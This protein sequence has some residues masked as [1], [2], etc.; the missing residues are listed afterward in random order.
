MLRSFSVLFVFLALITPALA[1]SLSTPPIAPHLEPSSVLQNNR[2]ALQQSIRATAFR[3]SAELT[4]CKI[5][6]VGKAC[7]NT[8]ISRK[9][10]QTVELGTP[11][12]GR[13]R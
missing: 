12:V 13:H 9:E 7:G 1:E 10:T 4:S 3:M 2:C 8:R 11:K 5:C 6:T